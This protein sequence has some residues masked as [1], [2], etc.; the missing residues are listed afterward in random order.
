MKLKLNLTPNPHPFPPHFRWR[1]P[2]IAGIS[3]YSGIPCC[4][5][6]ARYPVTRRNHQRYFGL[7]K[8]HYRSTG[9]SSGWNYYRLD[10]HFLDQNHQPATKPESNDQVEHVQKSVQRSARCNVFLSDVDALR[11][12]FQSLRY[13]QFAVAERMALDL[14]LESDD[15]FID[16]CRVFPVGSKQDL[17]KICVF[18]AS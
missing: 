2:R 1:H 3:T 14:L 13:S 9:S 18:G 12:V 4:N 17:G 7:W 6:I 15:I 8:S 11:D 5:I 10:F 16:S